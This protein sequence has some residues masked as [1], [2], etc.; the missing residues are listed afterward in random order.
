VDLFT[1]ADDPRDLVH[2][3]TLKAHCRSVTIVPLSP[4][5]ARVRSLPYLLTRTPLTIPYFYSRQLQS[6]VLRA[7]AECNYDRVFVYCS[8]MAQ[9]V[10][11]TKIPVVMDLVDVDSDKWRQYSEATRFPFSAIY[12]KEWRSLREYERHASEAAAC[13]VA[14]TS[15]EA[16]LAREIAP[17]ARVHS[18]P[19][20][21]DTEFFAPSNTAGR[22]EPPSV[23]FTGDM[24]YFPNQEAAIFFAREVLP[25]IRRQM[26]GVRFLVVGRNPDRRVESLRELDDVEVTG[27]VPD[28]RPWLSRATAAVAP[29]RIAAGIQN[30]ILEAMA[31]GLPV[32]A[33]PL[34]VQGLTSGVARAVQTAETADEFAAKVLHL[35]RNPLLARTAG[36]ESRDR[37]RA[38]Y[39][40]ERSL[41]RLLQL[42][43]DACLLASSVV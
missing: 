16:T 8:A 32:V 1:L 19:N 29:L 22:K 23:V 17:S 33:T 11:K 31:S 9:Y 30:K 38:D 5:L 28:V 4:M 27:F 7:V 40:W 39:S 6:L 25:L 18:I 41:N 21:V 42:L 3:N 35:L 26:P 13:V 2:E 36:L 34:A 15:R 20:G 43:S 24:S 37:V 14:S 12:R 10:Q